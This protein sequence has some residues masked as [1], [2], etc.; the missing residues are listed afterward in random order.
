MAAIYASGAANVH[1]TGAQYGERTGCACCGR[2]KRRTERENFEEAARRFESAAEH[3]EQDGLA[4][5]AGQVST[6][7]GDDSCFQIEE[8]KLALAPKRSCV[9][10]Q[11]TQ[12]TAE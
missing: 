5:D 9:R 8:Y 12:T 2:L 11:R 1:G 10:R 6:Y 7:A 4:G 3:A